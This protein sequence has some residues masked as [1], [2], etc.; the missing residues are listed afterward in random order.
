MNEQT[1]ITPEKR[2]LVWIGLAIV[3]VVWGST[4]LGIRVVVKDAP[5]LISMGLRF[6]TASLVLGTIVAARGGVRHLR[7]G[8][9]QALGAGFLGLML[10]MLGNGLVSVGEQEGAPSGFTALL[11]A[12]APLLIVV[13]RVAEGDRPRRLTLLGVLLGFAG[14]VFLVLAGSGAG[15]EIPLGP[16]LIVLFAASCWAFG[17]YVQRRLWLPADPFVTA[18]YEMLIGG[19]IATVVGLWSGERF[20]F[21]YPAKTWLALGYLVVFG[22]VVAFTAFVWLI[23]N[24][25]ISL[26]ATY[27]YVNPVIAVFLGWLILSEPVTVP[28]VVGGGVVVLAVAMVIGS[29]RVAAR[30]PEPESRDPMVGPGLDPG[31]DPCRGSAA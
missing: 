9:R 13:F 12:I 30:A 11:I 24:A 10:P 4:Y 28:I 1:V 16:A 3:Y 31:L 19:T 23:A 6:I 7:I 25:P 8:P 26:V 20:T 2:Y 14:L 15:G 18:V 21:A 22:S 5:P 27:A 29:E 17:S